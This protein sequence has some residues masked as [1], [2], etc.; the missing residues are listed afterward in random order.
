MYTSIDH[1]DVW[2]VWWH[3]DAARAK[4]TY[5]PETWGYEL[6]DVALMARMMLYRVMFIFDIKLG[7]C[8]KN[9][10]LAILECQPCPLLDRT[11]NLVLSNS[12]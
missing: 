5:Q 3:E 9:L 2:Q 4:S 12:A 10:H 8:L 1:I 11:A 7:A 6:F